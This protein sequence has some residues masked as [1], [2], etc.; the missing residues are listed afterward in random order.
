MSQTKSSPKTTNR[1]AAGR[2]RK[3]N[4]EARTLLLIGLPIIVIGLLLALIYERNQSGAT[5][6][7]TRLVRPDSPIYGSP[8]AP[9]TLVEFFDPECESCRAAYPAIKEI[10]DTYDGQVR[11]VLRYLPRHVNS[12]LA[13]ASIE[14]AGE[15]G[16]YWDMVDLLIT[17]QP[18]WGEQRVETPDVFR[19]YAQELGLDMTQYEAS[20]QN[21]DYRAKFDRDSQDGEALGVD[22]TPTFFVNGELVD[23]LSYDRIVQMI[24]AALSR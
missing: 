1:A 12:Y 22:G 19:A 6:D 23:P 8:D 11:L 7:Q 10:I 14:A 16:R 24:D 9:V 2:K 21:P 4:N 18:E 3:K 5:I 15:Q 17:R 20:M 13:A